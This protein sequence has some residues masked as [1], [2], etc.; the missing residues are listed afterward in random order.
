MIKG[1][2]FRDHSRPT[3]PL[4]D[5]RFRVVF[6]LVT[7]LF[8]SWALAASLNDILVRQFRRAL[9]LSRLGSSLVQ[10]AFYIGYFCAALPAGLLIRRLG[11]KVAMVSGLCLYAAGA[12]LFLPAARLQSYPLFLFGL[13]TIAIGLAF[14]ET[15]ANPFIAQ[16]GPVRTGAARLILSQAFWGLGAIAGGAIGSRFIFTASDLSPEQIARLPASAAAQVR[17]AAA[18]QVVPP[19]LSIGVAMLLLALLI[20][21]VRFPVLQPAEGEPAGS[22]P[23]WRVLAAPRLR[24]AVV[25]QFFYVGAQIGVLGFFVDFTREQLPRLN[26][27]QAALLLTGSLALLTVGRFTGAAL[28]RRWRPAQLLAGYAAANVALCVVASVASGPA[29]VACLWLTSFFMS[30][31]YPTIFTLGVEDLGEDASAGAS[32]LVMAIIGGAVI[33]PV[34]ARL[35]DAI[36][37]MHHVMLVPGGC[38]LVC[39]LFARAVPRLPT[40]GR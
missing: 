5:P 21:C 22:R 40:A 14:L 33:P 24:R 10:F 3:A 39:L 9:D 13:Y 26:D 28:G 31:M 1:A 20:G 8:V 38:F 11:Y 29:A 35:A 2:A 27:R 37:G 36:G 6:A 30:I 12:F 25:A 16:L 32:F 34:M 15:A 4:M 18:A 23:V 7:S 17:T 19:Y